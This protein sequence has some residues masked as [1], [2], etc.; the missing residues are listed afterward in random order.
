[1]IGSLTLDQL[2]VL[3]AI[4]DAGS[5]SAAG[6]KLNRAQS[7]ISQAVATLEG[8]QGVVVFDRSGHRPRLTE[9]G[10]VLIGQA[11]AVLASAGRFEALAA[12]TRDGIEPEL[13]IA[14]DPHVPAPP[15]AGSLRAL[16]DA[17]PHLPVS[18]STEGLGGAER[19][20]R[21]GDATLALCL[22]LPGVP[23]DIVALPLITEN[24]IAVAASVHPL[25]H[26]GRAATRD[27]LEPHVQLVLS[28][29]TAPDRP[30]YGIIGSKRWR[31]VDLGRRLDFLLAGLGWCRMPRRLVAPFMAEGR[32]VPL[33][34]DGDLD[35]SVQPLTVYAA[36][37]RDRP[38]GRAG[39]W[40]LD[41][42][43]D[44]CAEGPDGIGTSMGQR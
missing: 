38:P 1:M 14:I 30:G 37:L 44:R 21:G 28:D 23:D 9:V 5:F 32:L 33:S 36:H 13:A 29:P 41:D 17:F 7:A 11:R 10:R 40:L 27:D 4:A 43:R 3:V 39:R 16:R 19:R 8:A 25:A 22:L 20:L 35:P 34:I 24:L 12:G 31:F 2:R 26:L 42:L 18:F 15:L 6:R